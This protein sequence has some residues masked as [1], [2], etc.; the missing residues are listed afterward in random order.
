LRVSELRELFP[1][2]EQK[3]RALVLQQVSVCLYVSKEKIRA[4]VERDDVLGRV[5][6]AVKRS[7]NLLL[8]QILDPAFLHRRECATKQKAVRAWYQQALRDRF[9]EQ[10]GRL[11]AAAAALEQGIAGLGRMEFPLY[12]LRRVEAAD[13]DISWGG[14]RHAVSGSRSDR[15]VF[16]RAVVARLPARAALATACRTYTAAR[17]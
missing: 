3:L 7:G 14:L 11:P 8:E 4:V 12:R 1:A 15:T 2:D 5:V 13:V 17:A 6:P 16:P 9:P 10:R